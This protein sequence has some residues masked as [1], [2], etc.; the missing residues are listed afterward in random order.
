ML[1]YEIAGKPNAPLTAED[2]TVRAL[3]HI[4][5]DSK[6]TL[7]ILIEYN[8]IKPFV[9][10]FMINKTLFAKWF[11]WLI[12]ITHDSLVAKYNNFKFITS[13]IT[14]FSLYKLRS[15]FQATH[16]L[17][18]HLYTALYLAKWIYS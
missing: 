15:D 17:Y 2:N 10:F 3:K 7:K 12:I 4:H 9:S 13:M 1:H 11:F 16:Y 5:F 14:F 8:F 18:A 6:I